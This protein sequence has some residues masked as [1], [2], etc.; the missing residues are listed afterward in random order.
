M[1]PIHE[2]I[3]QKIRT[4]AAEIFAIK[5]ANKPISPT[6]PKWKEYTGRKRETTKWLI[7]LHLYKSEKYLLDN[8]LPSGEVNRRIRSHT[9]VQNHSHLVKTA[10]RALVR[11]V[12]KYEKEAVHV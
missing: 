12:E 1:H 3:R 8:A 9:T 6:S 7:M 4:L 5:E 2:Q 11:L 10:Q